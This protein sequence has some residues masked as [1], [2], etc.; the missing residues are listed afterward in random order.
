MVE[1]RCLLWWR[2]Q[3]LHG[4]CSVALFDRRGVLGSVVLK[5]YL[6]VIPGCAILI[7]ARSSNFDAS[8]LKKHCLPRTRSTSMVLL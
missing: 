4:W 7:A 1:R 5:L 2:V 3:E 6:E 8:D